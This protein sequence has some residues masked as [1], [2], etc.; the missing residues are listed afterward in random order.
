MPRID[1]DQDQD[2]VHTSFEAM[3]LE[4]SDNAPE[5]SSSA[6]TTV[7]TM[8]EEQEINSPVL[9]PESHMLVRVHRNR[10]RAMELGLGFSI[11][12]TVADL[13]KQLQ[14][15]FGKQLLEKFFFLGAEFYWLALI[16]LLSASLGADFL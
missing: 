12:T 7:T 3:D 15:Q 8:A 4:L 11:E 10:G 13:L 9:S 2:R 6:T 1:Q 5:S 14:I 16:F